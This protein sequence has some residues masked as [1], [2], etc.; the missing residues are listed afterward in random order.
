MEGPRGFVPPG[1]WQRLC[2]QQQKQA[3]TYEQWNLE[4]DQ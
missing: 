1:Q 2:R 4:N 3:E